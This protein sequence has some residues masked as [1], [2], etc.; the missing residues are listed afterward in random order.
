LPERENALPSSLRIVEVGGGAATYTTH[1]LAALG[2]SVV[3]VEA[4]GGDADRE[5]PSF[6]GTYIRP[7]LSAHFLFFN[8]NK[9]SVVLDLSKGNPDVRTFGDLMRRGPTRSPASGATTPACCGPIRDWSSSRK[10]RSG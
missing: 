1:F 6:G 4:P 10:R 8:A 2:A 9:Q 3:K 5:R 7:G